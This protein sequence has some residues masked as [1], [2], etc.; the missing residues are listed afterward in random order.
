MQALSA[1]QDQER[2][3]ASLESVVYE[4]GLRAKVSLTTDTFFFILFLACQSS[5]CSCPFY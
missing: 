3:S 5:W 1:L 4:N 2:D